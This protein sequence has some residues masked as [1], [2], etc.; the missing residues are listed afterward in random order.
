[1]ENKRDR[2]TILDNAAKRKISGHKS[3]IWDQSCWSKRL[4]T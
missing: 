4:S 2:I 1:M 3:G